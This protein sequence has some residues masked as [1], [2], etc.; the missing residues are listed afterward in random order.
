MTYVDGFVMAVPKADKQQVIEHARTGDAAF[1][2][3]GATRVLECW[4]DGEPDGTLTDFR[5]AV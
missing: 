5:K 4:A 2:E 3:Q 1:L